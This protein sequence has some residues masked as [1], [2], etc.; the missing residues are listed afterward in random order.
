MVTST[1]AAPGRVNLIGEHVDYNDG[2]VLPF[3]LPFITTARVTARS[4]EVVRVASQDV[5]E[6][7]FATTLAPGEVEDWAAYVG[8]VVWSLQQ[9]G[10]TV[11]GLDIALS[12]T[13]PLGAGLSSS[14]ALTC[15]VASAINDECSLGLDAREVADVSRVAENEFVGVPTGT[16]DQLASMLCESDHLLLLDCRSMETWSIPFDPA[17][18]GMTLLLIDSQ[19]RH[20][21]VG[22]EYGDRRRDCEAAAGELG[23]DSLREATL[24]QVASLA[25][26]RLRRRASH[27]VSEID[28]VQQVAAILGASSPADIGAYLTASH[29]S[30]RDDFEIS[31]EELDVLV[32]AAL[33]GGALGA[34]MTGG[35]FGGCAVVLCR[36]DD[37]E[38]VTSRVES[39]YEAHSWKRPTIWTPRPSQ[40]AHGLT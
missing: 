1:W 4:D 3:A 37:V 16:M 20:S 31:C 2:F 12:S 29:E 13:V 27:V 33:A 9:R 6:V 32:D 14:A 36:T 17:A 11:P 19:A 34:R 10:A 18:V 7:E 28:R 15:S 8:G 23:V 39:A 22:S 24:E 30:M 21:L 26:D 38:A 5:G 25:D 40:G 35:G